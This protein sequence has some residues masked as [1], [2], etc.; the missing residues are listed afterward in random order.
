MTPDW[1]TPAAVADFATR[2]WRRDATLWSGESEH[3][4]VAAHRLGWLDL[5]ASMPAHVPALRDFALEVATEGFTHVVLLGMGGSSLAPEVMRRMLGVQPGFLE[6][7]V[8]DDT[9]PATVR[10][11]TVAHDPRHTF[12]L[13]SSKSGGT[14]EVASFEKHFFEWAKRARGAQA[15]R[16]FAAITDPGSPLE[17]LAAE[18]GYR[19]T[20]ANPPDVGGRYSA[21]S[22]F[23]LVPAA[24]IGADP[25]ALL[26]GA[27]REL[28]AARRDPLGGAGVALGT[29]LG[30]AARGDRDKL[31][32]AFGP[33]WAPF[34]V[35]VE[36]L[37]AES[38]GKRGRGILPVNGE[39]EAAADCY[40][41]DRFFVTTTDLPAARRAQLAD[42]GHPLAAF[43]LQAPADLGAAFLRW[44]IATV[45]AGAV[46]GVDPFDEP[47]VSEAKQATSAAL[48]HYLAEHRF[49]EEEPVGHTSCGRIYA[50]ESVAGELEPAQEGQACS[51]LASLL[52]LAGPGD[53]FAVL[54]YLQATPAVDGRL[55]RLR[56]AA[57]RLAHLATTLGYGPRFLHS[58]GQLHKGGPDTGLFL[59]ITADEG[60]DVPIPGER[61]GFE[62]LRRA[63]AAGDY[64]VL[65]RRGRRVVR[66]H[67]GTEIERRLELLAAGLERLAAPGGPS[68][69]A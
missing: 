20:F 63:Q 40:G 15:G 61:Y 65:V 39:P 64:E 48:Q 4:Q 57:L 2:L 54:A 56:A 5:P 66:L 27:A 60:P 24:L 18:R 43:D 25:G 42:S 28:E 59:Q 1:T 21:L 23:G 55:Q 16:A 8:L 36:Q 10:A 17:K 11:V 51:W 53:Y 34:G 9:S 22:L 35:W 47:N 33:A 6:L 3:Q 50:P 45:A 14:L 68:P 19:R 13:V 31:T 49:A 46:L 38:T 12:F 30:L 37:V 7:A 52:G 67:L 58:T 62:A 41:P 44:E 29:Q 32:L 69:A 26:A